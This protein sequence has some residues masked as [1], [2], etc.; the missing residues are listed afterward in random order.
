MGPKVTDYDFLVKVL[1]EAMK[2]KASQ[3]DFVASL[4]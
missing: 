2:S 1:N 3:D 4:M